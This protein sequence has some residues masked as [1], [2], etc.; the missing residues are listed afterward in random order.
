MLRNKTIEEQ[1]NSPH[2]I[3]RYLVP[4]GIYIDGARAM[5]LMLRE[6]LL[7]EEPHS[8]V[9]RKVTADDKVINKAIIDLILS[10]KDKTDLFLMGEYEIRLTDHEKDKKGKLIKCRAY[11]AKK[12]AVY[13]EIN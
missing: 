12:T 1:I 3:R 6:H 13:Q 8:G 4:W 11:F 10:S 5:L 7:L 9:A 2:G